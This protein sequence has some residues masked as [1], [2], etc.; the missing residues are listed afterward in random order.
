MGRRRILVAPREIAGIAAGLQQGLEQLGYEVDVMFRWAHPFAYGFAESRSRLMRISAR[1]MLECVDSRLPR[2][3]RAV[4]LGVRVALCPILLLRYD[5]V[6]YIGPDT[7]LRGGL[8]RRWL[9]RLGMRTVTIF[10]GS[11]ARPPYMDGWFAGDGAEAQQ[12][13]RARAEVRINR[14]RVQAA[15][16]ESTYVVN[17]P[18]TA[19]FHKERF[20]DWTM[21]GF[22]SP[23]LSVPTERPY[24]PRR[25]LR[26]V[27][28][29]S[30]PRMKGTEEIRRA[31]A[32]LAA[33]GVELEFVEI[34]GRPHSE[35]LELLGT[36]DLVIDQLYSD[37]LLPG[38][39]T[40]A[41]RSG[42]PVL[43]LGH[44][45][46]MLRR[47]AERAHAPTSHY[48]APSRLLDE[49]RRAVTDDD[50]RRQL[51]TSLEAFVQG[52]WSSV[53]VA[54]RWSRVLEGKPDDAWF[55]Y[56]ADFTYVGGCGL[57]ERSL[58]TFLRAYVARFGAEGLD[59]GHAPATAAAILDLV[60]KG[61]LNEG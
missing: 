19:Q 48:H 50:H 10:C 25:P 42:A 15:E 20:I 3:R 35:V 31:V 7:L 13:E 49:L 51:R 14:M 53:R 39:A 47:L 18:G 52:S 29:P 27:H 57:S 9:T 11:E 2:V 58:I 23:P 59:L 41:A 32:A 28:A 33:E 24:N 12:L 46:A 61:S 36:A 26:L 8:D 21:L 37:L 22:P 40:E 55:D 56:P 54:E 44:A 43:V 5:V 4:S 1:A 17:H 38:L 30:M 6:V 45:E 60:R 16:R 34:T